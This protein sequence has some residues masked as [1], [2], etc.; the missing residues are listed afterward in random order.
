MS[1][2]AK[3]KV[4]FFLFFDLHHQK[5][6]QQQLQQKKTKENLIPKHITHIQ[7]AYKSNSK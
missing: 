2:N 7:N 4:N 6:N 5:Q 3:I 1:F